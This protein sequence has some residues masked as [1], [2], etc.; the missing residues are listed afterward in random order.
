MDNA[1]IIEDYDDLNTILKS[2]HK[3]KK[4]VCTIGSWDILHRGHVEYLKKAKESGDILVV[5]V[6]SDIAYKKYKKKPSLIPQEDRLILLSSIRFVD[7]VTLIFDVDDA[8]DWKMG[9]VETIH[10]DIFF[11]NYQSFSSKQRSMLGKLCDLKV[12]NFSSPHSPSV[13]ITQQ[14]KSLVIRAK[15]QDLKMRKSAFLL[16]A[17]FLSLSILTTLFMVFL[18]AF[19]ET[20]L[21][22]GTLSLLIVKTVPEIFGMMY[23]VVKY[24]FPTNQAEPLGTRL[25][26]L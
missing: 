26:N 5:G 9:L 25:K 19:K 2:E 23:I 13:V 4:I 11:C 14:L 22:Q 8:G 6:D 15:E 21:S 12:V 7:Y 20:N 24:L 3:D 1:S 16:L 17:T 18:T 10:P